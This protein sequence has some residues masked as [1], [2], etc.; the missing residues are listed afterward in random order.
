MVS[1]TPRNLSKRDARYINLYENTVGPELQKRFGSSA[2]FSIAQAADV[3]ESVSFLH[4]TTRY[5]VVGAIVRFM[6]LSG[7]LEKDG[8]KFRFVKTSKLVKTPVKKSKAG[9]FGR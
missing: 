4:Y 8:R 1:P 5:D 3:L 6:F 2:G 7:V 9:T